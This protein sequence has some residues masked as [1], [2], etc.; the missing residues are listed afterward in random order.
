[1]QAYECYEDAAWL[2]VVL[3]FLVFQA[4]GICFFYEIEAQLKVNLGIIFKKNNYI[5]KETEVKTAQS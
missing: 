4:L 3:C 5:E 2:M 1:M